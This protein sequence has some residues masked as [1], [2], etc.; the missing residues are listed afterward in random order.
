[1]HA[2]IVLQNMGACSG[3]NEYLFVI[4]HDLILYDNRINFSIPKIVFLTMKLILPLFN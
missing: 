2:K 3:Q 1:M 4:V